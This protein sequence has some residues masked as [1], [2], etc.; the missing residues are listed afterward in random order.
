M[1]FAFSVKIVKSAILYYVLYC[2]QD[3]QEGASHD[4]QENLGIAV[5]K[6][7]TVNCLR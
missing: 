2:L 6:Q 3:D 4:K 7:Y 5:L 1:V